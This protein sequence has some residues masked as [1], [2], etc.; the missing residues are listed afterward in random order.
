VKPI[1]SAIKQEMNTEINL[2][3]ISRS[4]MTVLV[5]LTAMFMLMAGFSNAAVNTLLNSGTW[6]TPANWSTGSIPT[7][8]DDVIIPGDIV[9]TINSAAICGS[10]TFG[11]MGA[12]SSITISGSNS[13][14]IATSGGRNGN[15]YFNPNYIS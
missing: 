4:K 3:K 12:A 10:L 1:Q 8:A 7:D 11:D 15:L 5:C 13:L 2:Q 6:E 9:V 14:T